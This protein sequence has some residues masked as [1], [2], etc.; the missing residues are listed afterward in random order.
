MA[1]LPLMFPQEVPMIVAELQSQVPTVLLSL[2]PMVLIRTP[3]INQ[4]LMTLMLAIQQTMSLPILSLMAQQ[5]Q[6]QP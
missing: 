5:L 1:V 2:V 4:P 3:L 6:R